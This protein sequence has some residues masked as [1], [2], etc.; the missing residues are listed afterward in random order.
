MENQIETPP[1][2]PV[3]EESEPAQR[4]DSNLPVTLILVALLIWFGFQ[5]LQLVRERANLS[6]AKASQETALRETE[7]ITQQFQGLMARTVELASQGHAGARMVV[8]ELQRRGIGVA[9]A[10]RPAEKQPTKPTK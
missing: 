2:A 7:K 6:A 4:T 10:V 1:D 8:E 5:S 3:I 9:P